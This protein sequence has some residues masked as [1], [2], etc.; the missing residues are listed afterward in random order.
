VASR[1]DA[2][3]NDEVASRSGCLERFRQRAHLPAD[4]RVRSMGDV[5]EL[6]GGFAEEKLDDGDATSDVRDFGAIWQ[7][8]HQE[9][10]AA[11][12]VGRLLVPRDHAQPASL[13]DGFCERWTADAASHGSQLDRPVAA[14]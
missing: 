2:L 12:L 6:T 9:V 10:G 14:N 1:L 13:V 3:G 11:A 4:E 7:E 5:D 8:R